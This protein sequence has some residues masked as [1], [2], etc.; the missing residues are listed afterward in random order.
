MSVSGTMLGP[1][2]NFGKNKRR[3]EIERIRTEEAYLAYDQAVLQAFRETEDALIAVTTYRDQFIA[4]ERQRIAAQNAAMLPKP[5][6]IK[7]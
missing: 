1:L 3:V 7:V 5:G 4:V 6:M 2:F